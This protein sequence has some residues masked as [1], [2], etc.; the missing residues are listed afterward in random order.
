MNKNED[1]RE[2]LEL[3]LSNYS[4]DNGSLKMYVRLLNELEEEVLNYINGTES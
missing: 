2:I 3:V 1:L 4:I